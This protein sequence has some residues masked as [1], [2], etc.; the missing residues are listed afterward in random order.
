MS[1]RTILDITGLSAGYGKKP[2][3][4]DLSMTVTSGEM[5]GLIGPNGAGKSTLLKVIMGILKE[6]KGKIIFGDRDV[7]SLPTQERIRLGM[8]MA[9][10]G[11][12]VF[13]DMTVKENLE[14]GGYLIEGKAISRRMEEMLELFPILGDMKSRN[15]GTLSGGEQQL[16]SLGRALMNRPKLLL[17]DEPSMG[18]DADNARRAIERIRDINNRLG[19]TILVVE[20]NVENVLE[21]CSIIYAMRLGEIVE[22]G[23]AERFQDKEL[24]RKIFMR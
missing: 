23:S 5:A 17:L 11:S 9:P 14:I 16:L 4:N 1:K 10:Q 19:V 15:A 20:Q 3:L 18:L 6:D 7:T 22:G 21:N 24:L 12:P 13:G 8:A 2:V